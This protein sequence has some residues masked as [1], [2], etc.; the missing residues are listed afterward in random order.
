MIECLLY[1][2]VA[3]GWY[4]GLKNKKEKMKV[5]RKRNVL[6]IYWPPSLGSALPRAHVSAACSLSAL[7]TGPAGAGGTKRSFVRPICVSA[8]RFAFSVHSVLRGVNRRQTALSHAPASRVIGSPLVRR[9]WNGTAQNT[10][11]RR[12]RFP[13]PNGE[14][15][16]PSPVCPRPPSP[17][18]RLAFNVRQGL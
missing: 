6:E 18:E 17:P 10:Q 8:T 5:K 9:R 14:N 1:S 16:N 4:N 13:V 11:T 15:L 7:V 12:E 2:L 3:V